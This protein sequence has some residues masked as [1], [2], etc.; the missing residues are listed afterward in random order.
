M[1]C[2]PRPMRGDSSSEGGQS[3][4]VPSKDPDKVMPWD[5]AG[6]RSRYEP[7]E[8]LG[9]G[10]YGVVLR[11]VHVASGEVRALKHPRSN[12][13]EVMARF[14]R[15]I[16]VMRRLDHPNVV[17]ILD[18][19]E[20]FDWFAMP[21]AASTLLD[22]A[23]GMSDDEIARVVIDVARGLD[24]A[25][26][27]GFIH[28]D[29]KPSN[30]LLDDDAVDFPPWRIADF[31]IVRRP[32]GEPTQLKTT[33]PIGTEGFMAPEV[34]VGSS[35]ITVTADIYGLGRTLAW[36]TTGVVP[37]RFEHIEG[38]GAWADLVSRMTE[39]APS[40]RIQQMSEVVVGVRAVLRKLRAER[41]ATWGQGRTRGLSSH[42]E[43]VLWSVFEEANEPDEPDQEPSA[44]IWQLERSRGLPKALIR[45]SI[46]KLLDLGYLTTTQRET[47]DGPLVC[48]AP[49]QKAWTWAQDYAD[50]VREVGV[51]PPRSAPPNDPNDDIP[52]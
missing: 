2:D 20:N 9:G 13:P 6:W 48:Y 24:A 4:G 45:V 51:E 7:R 39:I 22:A 52:F 44:S 29:V 43:K 40:S 21:L 46:K 30:I 11:V 3:V 33:R 38:R 16:E 36:A 34:A 5:L 31:G 19:D 1:W 26:R 17:R 15:E 14:K 10:G 8:E 42:D 50:R 23:R 12:E 49:T 37:E 35:E 32:P 25:H 28:R 18:H 27:H 47:N 41:A